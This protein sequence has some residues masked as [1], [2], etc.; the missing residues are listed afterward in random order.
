MI[1]VH[2]TSPFGKRLGN[3]LLLDRR[4]FRLKLFGGQAGLKAWCIVRTGVLGISK[5]GNR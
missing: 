1:G 4:I 5:Y 2:A 3:H